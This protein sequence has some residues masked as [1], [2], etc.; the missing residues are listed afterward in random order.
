[1]IGLV[2]LF[3]WLTPVVLDPVFNRYTRPAAGPHARRRR[4]AGAQGGSRRGDVLVVDASRRTTGANAYVV[5][6]GHTKR[7]VLYD[8]LLRRFTPA[9][10]RSWWRT[11]SGT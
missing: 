1:M 3:A 7:V 5:G 6:L 8:T 10:V 11:S 4:G 9:Q 2:V